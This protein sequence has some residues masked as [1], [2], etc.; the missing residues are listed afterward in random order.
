[1]ILGA[2]LVAHL[3]FRI[4]Y[5]AAAVGLLGIGTWG[6]KYSAC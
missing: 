1:M 3:D 2:V 6:V 4:L 5:L